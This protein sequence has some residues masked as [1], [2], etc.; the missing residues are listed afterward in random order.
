M[1][2]KPVIV[3]SLS[4]EEWLERFVQF[5]RVRGYDC[6]YA[7]MA[8]EAWLESNPSDLQDVP[9]TVSE[10]VLEEEIEQARQSL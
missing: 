7:R 2:E 6:V 9:E 8:G 3:P 10:D 1:T 5:W 4:R